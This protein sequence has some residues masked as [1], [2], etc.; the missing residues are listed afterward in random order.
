MPQLTVLPT[1]DD[2]PRGGSGRAVAG[3]TAALALL[4]LNRLTTDADVVASGTTANTGAEASY[5][6]SG[7]FF[8]NDGA[9]NFLVDPPLTPVPP[10]HFQKYFLLLDAEGNGRVQ[11]AMP[12]TTLESVSLANLAPN[13]YEAVVELLNAA[14][15]WACIAV[16]TISVDAAATAPFTPGVDALPGT[17]TVLDG[18]DGTI[19]LPAVGTEA[20]PQLAGF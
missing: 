3:L 7:E 19:M 17:P 1:R 2:L 6:I 14:P 16:V 4:T 15:G 8:H 9:W 11:E 18:F 13:P 20:A 5:T 10:G 12:G